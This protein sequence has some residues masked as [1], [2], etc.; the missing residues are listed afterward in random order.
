MELT[1]AQLT[2]LLQL[3]SSDRIQYRGN[4]VVPIA[5]L[6]AAL[7]RA[8]RDYQEPRKRRAPRQPKAGS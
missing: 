1:K 5:E 3:I 4:E 2:S 6:Q 8:I 7:S